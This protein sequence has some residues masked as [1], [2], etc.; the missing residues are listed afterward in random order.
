MKAAIDVLHEIKAQKGR[1]I[2]VLGDMLEMGDWGLM[3]IKSW[4]FMLHKS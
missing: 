4:E 2:A 3:L 1:A